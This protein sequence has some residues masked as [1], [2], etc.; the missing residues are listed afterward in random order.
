[1]KKSMLAHLVQLRA[2]LLGVPTMCVQDI[3]L[4][5]KGKTKLNKK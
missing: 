2:C 5:N 4:V 1:M 3:V